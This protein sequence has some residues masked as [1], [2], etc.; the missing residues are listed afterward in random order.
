MTAFISW[1]ISIII[2]PRNIGRLNEY[3]I[4]K[5]LFNPKSIK[6][7]YSKIIT[8]SVIASKA[9]ETISPIMQKY[10]KLSKDLNLVEVVSLTFIC[11]SLYLFD[12]FSVT[13]QNTYSP[14]LKVIIFSNCFLTPLHFESTYVRVKN[15]LK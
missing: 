1:I 5:E 2:L 9:N 10:L 13:E 8:R 4:S 7:S 14:L 3:L 6:S 12:V 15:Y 11:F